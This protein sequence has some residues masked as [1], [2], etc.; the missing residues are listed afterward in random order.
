[1]SD[2]REAAAGYQLVESGEWK[3]WYFWPGDAFEDLTGPFY[4]KIGEDGHGHCAFRAEARHMN[5][6]GFMH[7]GCLMTFADTA[8]FAIARAELHEQSAVTMNLGADF[9]NPVRV[10]QLVEAHGEITRGGGKTVFVR[11]MVTADGEP[12]LGF[13]GIIRKVARR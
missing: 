11:G 3:G 10:G 4:M 1:M 13:T 7:G 5:G 12:V 6:A 2:T 9:L 8:L